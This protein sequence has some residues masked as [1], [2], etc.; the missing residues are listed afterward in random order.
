MGRPIQTR[1]TVDATVR[2]PGSKSISNRALLLAALAGGRSQL[3]G[4]LD[5]DDTR[6][7][8]EVLRQ[9]GARVDI[10]ADCWT[11]S[12]TGGVLAVPTATLDVHA[13]GTAARFVAALQTLIP[14]PSRLDGTPRMQKRPIDDLLGALRGLG[15]D[16]ASVHGNGCPP[17]RCAGGPLPGGQ[18]ELDASR[19]S[20]YVSAVLQVA[21]LAASD[22]TLNLRDGVLV[23]RPYVDLTLAVMADFGVE[24]RFVDDHTLAVRHG[25]SYA[26][27]D[28]RI[29]PD[30][31]TAAYFFG[32]AAVTGG[33]VEVAGLSG[34]SAQ[35][36]MGL[37]EVLERMGCEVTREA[38]ATTLR[39][40]AGLHGVDVD[41]NRMPDAVLALAV[42]ALFAEGTTR[43]RNVANLRIKESDRLAALET[44]LRRL[45]AAAT[46]DADSLTIT[47]GTLRPAA[48][49]TYDDHRMAMAFSLAGL[50]IDG[51]E[52]NDPDCVSKSWPQYFDA[53]DKL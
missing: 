32:A 19:S 12:G 21:P 49:D 43:I 7:M 31:S 2:L 52:I 34:G 3:D 39:A 47:P 18:V 37:L 10:E 29:E 53:F 50:R 14:G 25:Q 9:L 23:S 13:S 1:R 4:V 41:M 20:Q 38:G 16:I 8:A 40:P 26:P 46:A 6:V 33:R 45:G 24:A 51:V 48:I 11:V 5:S 22:V 28:Y 36:D 27:R 44:E 17:V 30:A 35:A 42:I 15:A